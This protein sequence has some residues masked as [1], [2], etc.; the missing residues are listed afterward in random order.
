MGKYSLAEELLLRASADPGPDGPYELAREL[1]RLY[2]S[3]GRFGD[4]RRILRASWSRSPDAPGVL[5]E[6]W[7]LDHSAISI[8][9]WRFALDRADNDDDRVWLGRAHHAMLTGQFRAATNWI[10]A[11]LQRRPDDLAVLQARLELAMAT[12]DVAGFWTAIAH[13]P[14]SG[15][16]AAEI[17]RMRAWLAARRGEAA[18]EERELTLLV[19]VDPG[20]ARA[21]ERLAVL[22]TRAGRI[23]EAKRLRGRKAEVDRTQ[24]QVDLLLRGGDIDSGRA[25]RLARLEAELGRTFD[26]RAWEIVARAGLSAP[27]PS[28]GASS[29]FRGPIAVVGG[30]PRGGRGTLVAIPALAR[31][32]R[33][34]PIHPRRSSRRPPRP[35]GPAAR[36]HR[37]R[38]IGGGPGR[39]E[40]T[41]A[42]AEFVDDAAASGLRFAF[43]DGRTPIR[44]LPESLS[45]GVGL[46]DFDGDG[47]LDVYCVQGGDLRGG[48]RARSRRDGPRRPP[49]SQPRRR[50]LPGC[51]PRNPG[52][53]RS[54]G[55]GVM[56]R[57]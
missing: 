30:T 20:D 12:D 49:L 17:R 40:P 42:T 55:G 6:L 21:L 5:R 7:N 38:R 47:R 52:S 19:E 32:S 18:V 37:P 46:L 26:A 23:C 50:H 34:G 1:I 8:E 45:G 57:A 29:R 31:S 3:E 43:D 33:A 53:P 35:R 13:R 2:R 14:A 41:G 15:F 56:A 24:H 4:V 48:R 27:P 9:T 11:C 44:L 16:D 22:A 54:P 39:A 10:R 51:D 28:G 36:P 25:E